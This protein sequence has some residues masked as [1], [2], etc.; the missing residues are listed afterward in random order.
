[1]E[2]KATTTAFGLSKDLHTPISVKIGRLAGDSTRELATLAERIEH[3]E[4]YQTMSRV[5][6]HLE[7]YVEVTAYDNDKACNIIGVP[8]QTAYTPFNGALRTWNQ[9]VVLP[10]EYQAMPV[11][12]FLGFRV[13]EISDTKPR[14]YGSGTLLLFDR[15]M[16]TL[17]KGPQKV[18][19]AVEQDE[20][21]GNAKGQ[22]NDERR[23]N[24]K[25][26]PED[27]N[28]DEKEAIEPETKAEG[29]STK[30]PKNESSTKGKSHNTPK[31][32]S[33]TTDH[34]FPVCYSAKLPGLTRGEENMIRYENGE[35][36]RVP[37]LDKM[38]LPTVTSELLA[39][40]SL[41]VELAP[42]ELPI[43]YLA[44]THPL[45]SRPEPFEDTAQAPAVILN[46]VTIGTN[47]AK[48]VA[49][50]DGSDEDDP[51]E[52]KYHKLERNINNA[53][54]DKE[55]KPLPQVRDELLRILYK[56]AS[57]DLTDNEKNLI[58][59]FRYY[60]SKNN[61]DT[62]TSAALFLPKFLKS[63]DWDND[64]EVD[65]TF[66]EILP[67][68]WTV[69]KIHIGDALELL[70]RYFN[71]RHLAPVGKVLAQAPGA[72]NKPEEDKTAKIAAHVRWVREFAVK[73]LQLAN[74]DELLLYLLQ[75]VQ[76]LR[77]EAAS[78]GTG[79]DG[80]ALPLAQFLIERAVEVPK[81]GN[82]LY[83]YL[84]VENEDMHG[85]KGTSES[86]PLYLAMLNTYITSLK[87]YCSQ[88][89]PKLPY[90]AQ[91]KRQIWF[92]KKLTGLVDMMRTTFK[93]NEPTA[94]KLEY[95]CE[96]LANPS[97]EFSKFPEPFP[98]PLDPEVMVC[99]CYP[100]EL[101][102]F[103]LSLAPLKLTLKTVSHVDGHK[104][105]G[106][107]PLMFKIG[108]DL[109]QDQLVIQMIDLMDQ[110]LKNENLDLRLTPYKILA[111]SPAAGMIQFVP[112]DTLD[113]ILAAQYPEDDQP[114]P[115]VPQ[116]NGILCYLRKHSREDRPVY[117][118]AA[119]SVWYLPGTGPMRTAPEPPLPESD[120]GVLAVVMDNYVKLCAG[121]CVITYLL[122][123][124]DRHL[125]N[126]LLSPNGKFWHADFGYILGRD[127]KPFPPLMK[128]PI[129][130]VDGMGGLQHENF[131][132][133]KGYCF[134]TYTTLRKNLLLIL[135]LFEL[136]LDA[137]IPDI[138]LN[139]GQAIE[140]VQEKFGMDMSEE[141]AI[142]HFQ[143][144]IADSVQA[145]LPVVIDKLH[146]LAQYWR[147]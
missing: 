44:P 85:P 93:K 135:N 133:F 120:L 42:F 119:K 33:R 101:A 54:L 47:H 132:V 136:M 56:P 144:L 18:A 141:Q 71:P 107:Y 95:L 146:S 68:Y 45:A 76:A 59:K 1:M 121:Y 134:T 40:E 37:W 31:D 22:V 72:D 67:R 104:R 110:L 138:K 10:V 2:P 43:V 65:H 112:N 4:V 80:L 16:Y 98:L 106:K 126:L 115:Q 129:Q 24:G 8:V 89:S 96:Y 69:D 46:S 145:F 87:S 105:Y 118:P 123:V 27:K 58:W 26:A 38:V 130:V 81:L 111:T 15:E 86:V 147:A 48:F 30:E 90:Y 25:E 49:E 41:Y 66:N 125:D 114:T 9:T 32:K 29:E 50:Y 52:A 60:F 14:L 116:P 39:G 139:P 82:Y 12:G 51:I 57:M 74:N 128:L 143:N 102:V 61:A 79:D 88:H 84:K 113:T 83:W 70:G 77:Y 28:G 11:E 117:E 137:N 91:L 94:R 53:L 124:G 109:R 78:Y 142:V 73:R 20:R 19:I 108:D 35:F 75:L 100:S 140:K 62:Y 13:F 131:G 64:Y 36:P 23:M 122:G 7:L 103:K 5:A 55:I 97:N 6:R 34:P 3:P 17:R 99:G 63:L 21:N 92:V 127:P